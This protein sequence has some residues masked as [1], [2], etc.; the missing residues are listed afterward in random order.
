MGL[1][2]RQAFELMREPVQPGMNFAHLGM[3]S[4]RQAGL[5]GA[6]GFLRLFAGRLARPCIVTRLLARLLLKAFGLARAI[7]P[8]GTAR[9]AVLIV[10]PRG[11][12][13]RFAQ[14]WR[15]AIQITIKIAV[16]DT[17][18]VMIQVTI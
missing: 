11:G 12:T 10:S 13:R 15:C 1:R 5:L 2:P 4:R 6:G 8:I 17:I 18:Q 16:Q 7:V 9:G 3:G 14:S